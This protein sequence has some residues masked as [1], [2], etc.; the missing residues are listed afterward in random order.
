MW[1]LLNPWAIVG[2]V[3]AAGLPFLIH[4]LTQPRPTRLPYST[5]RFIQSALQERRARHRWRDF[6]VL[7]LRVLAIAAFGIALARPLTGAKTLLATAAP[8]GACRVVLLDASQSMAAGLDGV[9]GFE[10]GRSAAAKFLQYQP[11]L[12]A[13][14]ILAGARPHAVFEQPTGNL[15]AL[16]EEL[17]VA[18]IRPEQLNTTLALSAAGAMFGKRSTDQPQSM[19]LVIVSDFQRTNWS[20]ADFSPVPAEVKIVFESVAAS[21]N[22]GNVAVL[23]VRSRGR[24]EVGKMTPIEIEIAN[25]SPVKQTASVELSLG[26]SRY[27]LQVV[28]P[29]DS[30]ATLVAGVRLND[31]GWQSGAV[32][33]QGVEDALAA[34]NERPFVAHVRSARTYGLL[35]REP[36]TS[37]RTSYYV[38]RAL[39][40]YAGTKGD[41]G[42]RVLRIEPAQMD[43]STTRNV[44]LWVLARPGALPKT[45][46]D[47][48]A[49][50]L[51]HG[52]GVLYFASDRN[53][54]ANLT[55]LAAAL[56]ESVRM[57]VEYQP[58]PLGRP[59]RDL[60]IA[61]WERL[62]GP[63]AIFGDDAAAVFGSLRLSGGL[64]TRPLPN[65]LAAETL[66]SL[67][68]QSA[69]VVVTAAGAGSLAVV[70][71]DLT[72][73]NLAAS[74]AFVPL[75]GELVDRLLG[76][77]GVTPASPSGESFVKILPP[78]IE[79]TAELKLARLDADGGIRPESEASAALGTLNDEPTGVVWNWPAAG[80][81]GVYRVLRGNDPIYAVAL[82]LP[83]AES[84]LRPIAPDLLSQRLAYGRTTEYRAVG[85]D[86]DD[87][88]T[89]RFWVWCLAAC[90][91][92]MTLEVL[93]LRY[94]RT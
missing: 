12:S 23:D 83:A 5:I 60:F 69:F 38:E 15:Q 82:A 91:A 13:N 73:S 33:L 1:S 3:F 54:A 87:E 53:D 68:D 16:R 35:T 30:R 65:G 57:P 86:S 40:P 81:P 92:F 14:L 84:D 41:N 61:R 63:F 51:R 49:T 44:D 39:A 55:Q 74:P 64:E 29:A 11:S 66:A 36:A 17:A 90:S 10:R 7:A 43:V 28:C 62:H 80:A 72:E 78:E 75:T 85:T 67:S 22:P 58:P 9:Q 18:T 56:G 50:R 34:D 32:R 93:T 89:D 20:G 79:T 88:A 2:A 24:I 71:A 4:W 46:I 19:E 76:R 47:F 21:Q 42:E 6:I 45:A 27:P 59:R 8:G 70:N 48:L 94:F 52:S 77:D 26:Q 31:A 37:Q 25:Y